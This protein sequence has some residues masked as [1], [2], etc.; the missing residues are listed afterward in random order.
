MFHVEQLE[1]IQQ[2]PICSNSD[3]AAFL[4]C[5]DF[6]VSK[7][8]F[9]IVECK[10]CGFAF[11]NPRP[12]IDQ[13]GK[14]YQSED[15]ISHSNTKKGI[16][17]RLYQAVRKRTLNS[18]L[19]LLNSNVSA[20]GSLLDIG[21]G[22]GE[23]LNVCQ[24][25]GWKVLGIEPSQDARHQGIENY[26]LEI[27]DEANLET[28]PAASF[29][30]ITMWHVL[31]HVPNLEARVKR[32]F[33]LLKPNG[34]FLVAVPNRN[35]HDAAHYGAFWAAYDV[36]RHLWHFRPRDM[37]ALMANCGFGVKEIKPM[38]FD[39]YYVSMLSEKYKTG[40]VRFIPA[41]WRGWVSNRKAGQERW[42]SQIYLI[43]KS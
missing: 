25:D 33:E 31:E 27:L 32:I 12:A 43:R 21:C 13:L 36:P 19:R 22:T 39:S 8:D 1:N 29:D 41:I 10:G 38:K 7:A 17:S 40:R 16:V 34:L 4:T 9:R 5:K 26:K 2:C 3:Q 18:K 14:Y 23:F 24:Q 35:S 20:K 6:T 28:L 42:S 37:R 15:Y 11:T 30:A